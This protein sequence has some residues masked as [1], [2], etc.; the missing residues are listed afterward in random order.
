MAY[1]TAVSISGG[2]QASIDYEWHMAK[3]GSHLSIEVHVTHDTGSGLTT[4]DQVTVLQA[5]EESIPH[6]SK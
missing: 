1:I 5:V 3:D 2:R 6:F 4:H